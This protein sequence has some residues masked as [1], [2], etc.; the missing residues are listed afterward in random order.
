LELREYKL[1]LD[2]T[3]LTGTNADLDLILK[4]LE[5]QL[6]NRQL[7]FKKSVDEPKVKKVWFLDNKNHELYRKNRFI[8]RIKENTKDNNRVEYDITFKVRTPNK[9]ILDS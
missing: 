3:Q 4:V 2:A 5:N 9:E 8:I 1:I 7:I 6:D